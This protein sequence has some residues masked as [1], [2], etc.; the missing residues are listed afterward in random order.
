M[1]SLSSEGLQNI[2]A[3]EPENN[4]TFHTKQHEYKTSPILACFIS[5]LVALEARSDLTLRDFYLDIDDR[6]GEFKQILELMEGSSI[7]INEDNFDFLLLC[8]QKLGN[9]ELQSKVID[10]KFSGSEINNE[11]AL[12]RMI[13]VVKYHINHQETVDYIRDHFTEIDYE[14]YKRCNLETLIEICSIPGLKIESESKLFAFV[15]QIVSDM[16]PEYFDLYSCVLL[17]YLNQDEINVFL[18]K[19]IPELLTGKIWESI[20][21]RLSMKVFPD[22]K[23]ET[24]HSF[25]G[26]SND[27]IPKANERIYYNKEDQW[28]GIINRLWKLCGNC[29]PHDKNILKV[30]VSTTYNGCKQQNVIDMKWDNYWYS[31]NEEN[32][33]FCIDFMKNMVIPQTYVLRSGSSGMSIRSWAFEGSNDAIEWVILDEHENLNDFKTR[34]SSNVYQIQNIRSLEGTSIVVNATPIG[35]R[36]FM[37]DQMPLERGDLDKL[38]PDT[39]IYDIVYNPTKTI[40]IQE[41]QKRGLRTIGGLEML[42]YQGARALEIWTGKFPDTDKMKIAA[43]EAL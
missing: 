25:T 39:I 10:W 11:N 41:A 38:N 34:F 29:N 40:L 36:G 42:I 35:M 20:S 2:L 15:N 19:V 8:A 12:D 18:S 21:R 43:L 37:A 13:L 5:P 1:I 14:D 28:N 7:E 23:N 3:I 22:W 9:H 24:R 17:E 16:G 6:K 31:C 26:L 27:R 4:F 33:F 30:F 32:S